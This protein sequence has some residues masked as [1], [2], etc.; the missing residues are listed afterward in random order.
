[1]KGIGDLFRGDMFVTELEV[2]EQLP[3]NA[4]FC[5]NPPYNI[6]LHLI[7]RFGNVAS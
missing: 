5:M 3:L 7:T 1:M 4:Q 2:E 6:S